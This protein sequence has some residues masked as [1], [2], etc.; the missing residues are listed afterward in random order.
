MYSYCIRC[1]QSGRSDE[2]VQSDVQSLNCAEQNPSEFDWKS[3]HNPVHFTASASETSLISNIV[4]FTQIAFVFLHLNRGLVCRQDELVPA[5]NKDQ[6]T[7]Q[8]WRLPA[9]SSVLWANLTVNN[10]Q[11]RT[12]FRMLNGLP[13][14]QPCNRHPL[15]NQNLLYRNSKISNRKQLDHSFLSLSFSAL[16]ASQRALKL[17]KG[18]YQHRL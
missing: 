13:T 14:Q 12:L 3:C 2:S 8:P 11:D 16:S 5:T 7:L 15:R 17:L 10:I 18:T 4:E 6:N 1:A 9:T